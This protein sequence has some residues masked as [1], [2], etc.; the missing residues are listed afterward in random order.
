[1]DYQTYMEF[2]A[3]FM[4]SK[5]R[6]DADLLAM[7]LGFWGFGEVD[8]WLIFLLD[9]LDE[10]SYLQYAPE[11]FPPHWDIVPDFGDEIILDEYINQ[12]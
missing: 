4:A 9:L 2:R 6:N 3:A 8:I 7:S 1:V 11:L 10:N 5:N 12:L